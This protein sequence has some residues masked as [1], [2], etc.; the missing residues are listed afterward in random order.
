MAVSNNLAI[1]IARWRWMSKRLRMRLINLL[2]PG[3]AYRLDFSTPFFG[4]TY[5]GNTRNLIDRKVLFSGCHECDVLAFM[6]DFLSQVDSPVCLDIG[7][8]VGHHALFMSGYAARVIAFEPYDAVRQQMVEKL[9]ENGISNVLI[10]TVA[11]GDRNEEKQF[12]APPEENLGTGSFV[13]EFSAANQQASL[14]QVRRLDDV[15][16]DLDIERV[17]FIKLDVEGFEKQVLLGSQAMLQRFRPVVLFES[18][19]R[20]ADSLHSTDELE[21]IYP[22][23]YRFYRFTHSGKRRHGKYRV[24]PISQELMERKSELAILAVPD[25]ISIPMQTSDRIVLD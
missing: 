14:L 4:F 7:A 5:R 24:V 22:D 25:E 9:E 11:L 8:N 15:V 3:L 17:D 2:S 20:I 19:I 21:A 12:F 18:S 23:D 6:R 10:E 1:V 13:E 16:E